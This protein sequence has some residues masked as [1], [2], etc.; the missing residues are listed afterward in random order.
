MKAFS[1]L[2][3][4]FSPPLSSL[5]FFL[6]F[7]FNMKS[8]ENL[9][10]LEMEFFSW[11]G[12]L[13]KHFRFNK[14]NNSPKPWINLKFKQRRGIN[15]SRV[16]KKIIRVYGINHATIS[17]WISWHSPFYLDFLVVGKLQR[18]ETLYMVKESKEKK[19]S[20]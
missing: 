12:F 18:Y 6:F 16:E 19:P 9:K 14:K 15:D 17:K 20:R 7:L 5:F 13:M 2:H 8:F 11:V 3:S 10:N 4:F 1:F